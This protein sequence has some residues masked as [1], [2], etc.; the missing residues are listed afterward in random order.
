MATLPNPSAV[1]LPP[2]ATALETG[3]AAQYPTYL[4][5]PWISPQT[6]P[7]INDPETCP[8]ALLAWLAWAND[9]FLWRSDW[10]DDE[11]RQWIAASWSDHVLSGTLGGLEDLYSR[12]GVSIDSY[13]DPGKQWWLLKPQ[14]Q[15]DLL[16]VFPELR[17]S[18]ARPIENA[19][20]SVFWLGQSVISCDRYVLTDM[21]PGPIRSAGIYVGGDLTQ[22][23]SVMSTYGPG[24]EGTPYSEQAMLAVQNTVEQPLFGI[25]PLGVGVLLSASGLPGDLYSVDIPF[26]YTQ[27]VEPEPPALF[28]E[29][30]LESP[31]PAILAEE[32]T[33]PYPTL[34]LGSGILGVGV[35]RWD[36]QQAEDHFSYVWPIATPP[37]L[38]GIAKNTSWVG[39]TVLNPAPH[40]LQ[41][42]V[43][44][45]ANQLPG[46]ILAPGT[47]VGITPL[48]E[49]D[50]TSTIEALYVTRRWQRCSDQVML[51][52]N[53]G[54]MWTLQDEISLSQGVR[55]G[56]LREN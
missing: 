13:T 50:L 29:L 51:N 38:Q 26:T 24:S 41:V 25:A 1:L 30:P 23:V 56:S 14:D 7:T 54:R 2:N 44:I 9:V 5:P 55:L 32:F 16:A 15:D 18:S 53:A 42:T 47:W 31:Y 19:P 48:V 28:A 52:L 17:M 39:Q 10:K 43:E 4:S 8:S 40:E 22:T 37:T 12:L 46:F 49:T 20:G 36:L 27:G 6:L 45:P 34:A 35:I 21:P 33:L 11:K 3:I